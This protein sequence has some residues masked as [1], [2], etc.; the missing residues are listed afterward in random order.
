[1]QVFSE[2]DGYPYGLIKDEKTGNWDVIYLGQGEYKS[3]I[4][5]S[6]TPDTILL[7]NKVILTV[8][9]KANEGIASYTDAENTTKT[10]AS[11]TT[12][13]TEIFEVTAN[14]EYTFTAKDINGESDTYTIVVS[15]ISSNL[16]SIIAT[17][18]NEPTK[19]VNVKVTWPSGITSEEKQISTDNGIT[20]I[21]YTENITELTVNQN[22]TIKAK[23][24]A[25]GSVIISASLTIS[26]IDRL[27]PNTFGVNVGEVT[28]NSISVSGS[29]TDQPATD[30]YAC[31]GIAAY[32]FSK[33]GGSTWVNNS[34][35][36]LST[37]YTFTGLTRA[38]NYNLKMKA[39]DKAGN[40]TE[41]AIK[42]QATKNERIIPGG[43]DI[44]LTPSTTQ[45]TKED[46]TVS[47]TWPSD[48]DGLTKQI[49]IDNGNT[50][51][52]YTG[53]VTISQNTTVKARL[54]EPETNRYGEEAKLEIT[55]ID[56]IAP[57]A[58][59]ITGG[60]TT[61]AI[62][63]KISVSEA[64]ID[65]KDGT[66]GSGV[67][68]YEYYESQ[69]IGSSNV[70]ISAEEQRI[71][72][73]YTDDVTNH[74][75]Y[76]G[77]SIKFGDSGIGYYFTVPEGVNILKVYVNAETFETEAGYERTTFISYVNGNKS[78]SFTVSAH[79]KSGWDEKTKYIKVTPGIEYYIVPTVLYEQT[80]Q[81]GQTALKVTYSASINQK[82]PDYDLTYTTVPTID[83]VATGKVGTTASEMSK[84]FD[85]EFVGDVYFR[86]VDK[87]GNIGDWSKGESINIITQWSEGVEIPTPELKP[88]TTNW[89]NTSV[90]V[91]AIWPDNIGGLTKKIS[92]DGTNNGYTYTEPV[93]VRENNTVV[94]AWLENTVTGEKG[95]PATLKITNID[96]IGPSAPVIVGGS[97]EQAT[98]RTITIS[99]EAVDNKDGTPGSGI[100]RYEYYIKESSS[101]VIPTEDVTLFEAGDQIDTSWNT[102]TFTVQDGVSVV[103]IGLYA[104]S[105]PDSSDWGKISAKIL[106]ESGTEIFNSSAYSEADGNIQEDVVE[107][108]GVESGKTYTVKWKVDVKNDG[109]YENGGDIEITC[110]QEINKQ[111]PTNYEYNDFRDLLHGTVNKTINNTVYPFCEVTNKNGILFYNNDVRSMKFDT[112]F[113]GT[114]RVRAIDKAGNYGE[115]SEEQ[116]L[117]IMSV[118]TVE[119]KVYSEAWQTQYVA[120][121]LTASSYWFAVNFNNVSSLFTNK[122][123]DSTYT[124]TY[125]A[126]CGTTTKQLTDDSSNWS[127]I[128]LMAYEYCNT[129]YSGI[130]DFWPCSISVTIECTVK[131]SS[132]KVVSTATNEV[133][134]NIHPNISYVDS[135]LSQF[136]W[137]A[138][139]K[140]NTTGTKTITIPTGVNVVMLVSD[141]R[142]GGYAKCTLGELSLSVNQSSRNQFKAVFVR[143]TPGQ[144]YEVSFDCSGSGTYSGGV[145]YKNLSS[146][147][148]FNT[149]T[150]GY[151]LRK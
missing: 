124:M 79:G 63:R 149:L 133:I 78:A 65:N 43:A 16:I 11:G 93:T 132:G 71:I 36:P 95:Q 50:W 111:V 142:S 115:W 98:N 127:E 114:I 102:E 24:S 92:V 39:V 30:K 15:N 56:K 61:P 144:Q 97:T 126:I 53:V 131:D 96:K 99:K 1:M 113:T 89:T 27:P 146:S 103:K 17:P 118:P 135:G 66:K 2:P 77:A 123:L 134:V 88:S 73:L 7:A 107:Y 54:M 64:S 139:W 4:E 112:D 28:G 60:S 38:T 34:S 85:K 22:G 119:P 3:D 32:Y 137:L 75:S 110:S 48:I 100:S 84:I 81:T 9:I 122:G 45:W 29:T 145:C 68:Y 147:Y 18:A 19:N 136:N 5:I 106:D 151:D 82:T 116:S 105:G 74:V 47:A 150:P 40:E 46:I 52:T 31:S 42:V 143:V 21:N 23:V 130:S 49:S 91:S 33:D 62:S 80:G 13:T 59:V 10:Y 35:N 70:D 141:V 41:T 108:I 104:W 14:G 20:W 94:K 26:N 90:T 6:V 25:N 37:S 138:S 76:L 120:E 55:N 12:E 117:N 140:N 148:N 86:A 87:A 58:P 67:A 121:G 69:N 101:V 51:N 72:D 128:T 129:K 44:I 83:T 109:Y 57:S 125:K 8:R